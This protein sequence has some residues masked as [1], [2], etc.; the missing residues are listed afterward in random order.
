MRIDPDRL[1]DIATSSVGAY[2]RRGRIVLISACG[3][4]LLASWWGAQRFAD[5]LLTSIP[6]RSGPAAPIPMTAGEIQAQIARAQELNDQIR[7]QRAISR[8]YA[9]GYV[10]GLEDSASGAFSPIDWDV[11]GD[12]DASEAG[13]G[14]MPAYDRSAVIDEPAEILVETP[15][16][17]PQLA[18][19]SG[20]TGTVMVRALIGPDGRVYD[21]AI[22]RSIPVLNGAAQRAVR[23][24][25][26][27]PAQSKG[28]P[29]SSWTSVP[30]T[31][32]N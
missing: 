4:V 3:L 31:F 17:I 26:F 18:L 12:A 23:T 15:P 30:V 32:T 29:V 11:A 5:S 19:E 2:G 25:R 21:T 14:G 24:W 1:R 6:A 28:R 16:E 9:M 22:E 7:Q 27:R 10:G 20:A 13:P 8:A